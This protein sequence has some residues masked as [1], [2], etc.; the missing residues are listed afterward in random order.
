MFEN[1]FKFLFMTLGKETS[2]VNLLRSSSGGMNLFDRFSCS[3][4]CYNFPK[5]MKVIITGG[6]DIKSF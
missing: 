1:C 2:L 4:L 6:F 3:N 5:R